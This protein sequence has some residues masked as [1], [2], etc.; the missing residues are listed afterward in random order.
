MPT[1]KCTTE[2]V[3]KVDYGDLEKF[4]KE[5]TGKQISVPATLECGNDT[6]HEI[7]VGQWGDDDIIDYEEEIIAFLD[8][9]AKDIPTYA[10]NDL[11]EMLYKRKLIQKG[12]YIISVSW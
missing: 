11:M 5:L 9:D 3:F 2:T 12:S 8:G 7:N 6:E 4:I 10:L 1:L